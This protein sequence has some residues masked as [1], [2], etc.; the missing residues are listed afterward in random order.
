MN[1]APIHRGRFFGGILNTESFPLPLRIVNL[2]NGGKYPFQ[3][4][5]MFVYLWPGSGDQHAQPIIAPRSFCTDFASIPRPLQ[6]LLDADNDVAPGATIHDYLYTSGLFPRAVCDQIFY[7]ALRANGVGYLRAKALYL[8][9]R[10]GGAAAW[11]ADPAAASDLLEQSAE[12]VAIWE[13]LQ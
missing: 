13:R 11:N 5:E 7:E 6:G 2:A 4:E 3:L 1:L 10:V 8:G 12:A 9:V